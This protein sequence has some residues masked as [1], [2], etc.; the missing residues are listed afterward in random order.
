[1]QGRALSASFS[2]KS[3]ISDWGEVAF[4]VPDEELL[5]F[6]GGGVF[7]GVDFLDEAVHPLAD[8]FDE[9]VHVRVGAFHHQLNPAVGEVFDEAVDLV[10]QRDV[11]DRVTEPH[12]LDPAGEVTRASVHGRWHLVAHPTKWGNN[13]PTAF[14]RPGAWPVVIC[15]TKLANDCSISSRSCRR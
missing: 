1:M 13:R 12:P 10:L 11:L 3:T 6:A 4:S 14:H 5:E 9:A 7:D 2:P 15:V 8:V